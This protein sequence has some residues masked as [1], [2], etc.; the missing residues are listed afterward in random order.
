MVSAVGHCRQAL[1]PRSVCALAWREACP[2][3]QVIFQLC[4]LAGVLLS[5][6]VRGSGALVGAFLGAAAWLCT[7]WYVYLLNGVC[8]AVEDRHNESSS[9]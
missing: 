6:E 5:L 9:R 2:D 3:V 7:T 1:P 4:Y 8:D